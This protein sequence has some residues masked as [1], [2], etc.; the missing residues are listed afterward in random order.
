MAFVMRIW[1]TDVIEAFIGTTTKE[2][3]DIA[4]KYLLISTLFYFFLGQIFIYRNALQGMG[5]T[6]FPLLACI[7]ELVMRAFAAVYLAI[8]FGY[9]GMFYAGPIAWVSASTIMFFGY[10]GSIK[11]IIYKVKSKL[12]SYLSDN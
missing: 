9:I 5:E 12:H 6:L 1:G 4:H 2:I 11:H 3:I 10:F 8:K 7:A